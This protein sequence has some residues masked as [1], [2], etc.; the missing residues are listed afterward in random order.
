MKVQCFFRRSL[1]P[2]SCSTPNTIRFMA[3]GI[4]KMAENQIA[5][6]TRKGGPESL[7]GKKLSLKSDR[8]KPLVH[9]L[10]LQ[11]DYIHS[12]ILKDNNIRPD[13]IQRRIDLDRAWEK[14][15][16][17]IQNDFQ[18]EQGKA[19]TNEDSVAEYIKRCQEE[20][21]YSKEMEELDKMAKQV[22]DAIISDSM[23]F[24]GLSPVRHA[25]RFDKLD[26]R[27]REVLVEEV[28]NKAKE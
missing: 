1:M 27:I 25:R 15:K 13:S 20:M 2:V 11:D 8:H 5:E 4:D 7:K 19:S 26:E 22:N 9:S 16:V 28:A 3:S 14:L 24:N 21:K 18:K 12:K 10:G 23:R 17:E 6:W